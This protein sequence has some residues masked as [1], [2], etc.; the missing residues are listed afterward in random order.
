MEG[1]GCDETIFPPRLVLLSTAI[2]LLLVSGW[3]PSLYIR[4]M[5]PEI[6]ITRALKKMVV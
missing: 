6:T 3:I 2:F 1:V 5:D 4:K